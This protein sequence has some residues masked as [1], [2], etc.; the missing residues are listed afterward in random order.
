MNTSLTLKKRMLNGDVLA[1]TFIKTP[2]YEIVEIMAASGLDFICLDAEHAPFDRARLDA[3][4]AMAR[5]HDLPTLVRVSSGSRDDILKVLDS[6]ATG[7]VIP[8]VDSI[9][10][11]RNIAA[12]GRFGHGGRGYAGSTRWAGFTT[13]KM[14]DIL[15]QS[16]SET[17]VIAQIEEPEGVEICEQIAAV[18]GIDGLFVGPADLAVCLGVTDLNDPLVLDAMKRVGAAVKGSD[19]CCMTFAP[20]TQS[21]KN[22]HKLGVTMFYISSEHGFMLAGARNAASELS[23]LS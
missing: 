5:A 20:D 6:G 19:C 14:P 10:K 13:R 23:T 9:E 3:C 4:L 11:A 12:W 1:G 21:A 15:A 7:V 8:H 16:E 17:I 18:E 22:L 2:A